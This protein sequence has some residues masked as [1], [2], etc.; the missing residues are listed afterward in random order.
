MSQ[1]ALFMFGATGQVARAM[2]DR[3]REKRFELTALARGDAD[4]SDPAAIR[5][6]IARA[7]EGAVVVNAAA[8]TAVDQAESEPEL[9]KAINTIAP[10]V[11]AEAARERGLDFIHISTDYVFDGEKLAPYTEEDPTN[12]KGV[13]GRT[14]R[15]GERAVLAAS[16][17]SVILRTSWVYSPYGKNFLKTMLRVGAERDEL[18]VVD[19]QVGAPTSAHDIADGILKVC[20]VRARGPAAS[21][22]FHLT[23]TGEASWADFA[24]AIFDAQTE[25]W[26]RRPAVARI[27]TK[28]YPT[29]AARP[30]NSRLSCERL[31]REYGF[32]A[33]HWRESMTRVLSALNAQ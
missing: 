20:G 8:Y 10:G 28:D 15:D 31:A 17:D 19:D 11:M 21:G 12:P 22:I 13:Y 23:G 29:P 3:A 27:A 24:D 25:H 2:A 33:P 9:A 32:R 7:P 1:S 18:R 26:G 30:A 14:K 16:E 5:A 4:L 6:A